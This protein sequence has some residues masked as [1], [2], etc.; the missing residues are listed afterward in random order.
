LKQRLEK[1]VPEKTPDSKPDP[2]LTKELEEIRKSLAKHDK[3]VQE[4]LAKLQGYNTTEQKKKAQFFELQR[5]LQ[6]KIS[7]A[8]NLERQL[9]DQKIEMARLETRREALEEEMAQELGE[10]KERVKETSEESTMSGQPTP[11]LISRIQKLKYKLNLIGGI[12]SEAISEYD[13]T[14]ERHEFLSTQTI[15]LNKA[16]EDLEKVIAELDVTIKSRS[17]TAFRNI[18]RE[19]GRYF[20]TLFDGGE[21]E[22]IQ[23]RAEGPKAE[24]NEDGEEVPQKQ[25]KY[26]PGDIIGIE[27]SACPP[28]KKIKSINMLSGGEKAMTSIA[29][30]C[31]IM[32]TNPSPFVVLDEVDAALDESNAARFASIV[33]EL[34]HKTQFIIITHNRYTMQKA[35][36][37]YGVT[38]CEDGT[39]QLLSVNLDKV[40]SLKNDEKAPVKSKKRTTKKKM[41]AMAV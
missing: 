33:K 41:P 38:M 28:G 27:I 2:K 1:P 30:I 8:H 25:S 37:L 15:D 20:S 18:N 29:L 13:E 34:A 9:H 24:V 4:S 21:A 31:S 10:S 32:T 14:K 40:G 11:D 7:A 36:V 26:R 22:L 19:F 35:N 12:D 3:L 17:E 16:I 6:N 23:I 5:G 39:S